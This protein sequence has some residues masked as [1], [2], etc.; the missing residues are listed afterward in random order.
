[1][2]ADGLALVVG[3]SKDALPLLRDRGVRYIDAHLW[4]LAYSVC[5]RQF[6]I[7]QAALRPL[8]CTVSQT[9]EDEVA[10]QAAAY[11]RSIDTDPALAGFW[12]L[13][14]YPHGEIARVL[15]RLRAVVQESNARTGF[16][17][18]TICGVGGSL[19]VKRTPNDAAF[20][21]NHGYMDRALQNVSPAACDMVSPYFYAT[22]AADDPRLIDWSM[23]DLLPY[24]LQALRARGYDPS[25]D[26]LLP[27]AQA[28]SAHAAGSTTYYVTPRPADIATQ[29][30]A[31]CEHASSVLFFTWRS[32][33]ADRSYAVTADMKSG[34]QQG[35]AACVQLWQER[36]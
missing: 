4:S 20:R 12:I 27:I 1:M 5:E 3:P 28:F 30:T 7:E 23:H 11:L 31:Y 32:K 33:D 2:T 36:E 17:R 13:D 8:A 10:T 19:D 24:F 22:A 34:V 16:R 6:A 29:M 25:A 9:D 14:D 35:R 21:P 15:A 18:F 26:V